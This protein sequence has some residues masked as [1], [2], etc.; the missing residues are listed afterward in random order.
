MFVIGK[1]VVSLYRNFRANL[2]EATVGFNSRIV[3]GPRVAPVA[4]WDHV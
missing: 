1:N 4:S 3:L 2:F